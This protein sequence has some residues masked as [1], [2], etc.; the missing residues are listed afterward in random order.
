MLMR[1]TARIL[2]CLK[3]VAQVRT[4]STLLYNNTGKEALTMTLATTTAG[5][6]L[7]PAVFVVDKTHRALKAWR[8]LAGQVHLS[9]VDNRWVDQEMWDWYVET[10]I[11]SFT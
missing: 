11:V 3:C 1:F 9:L 8:P 10:V 5:H 6:M 4:V 2:S 7:K